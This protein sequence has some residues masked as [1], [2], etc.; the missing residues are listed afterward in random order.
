MNVIS[1]DLGGTKLTSAIIDHEGTV[2]TKLTGSVPGRGGDATGD[3]ICRTTEDLL[4]HA[5]REKMPVSAIGVAVP[6]IYRPDSG[7]VWA[8]NIPGWKDYPLRSRIQSAIN[9][10]E[11]TIQVDSDRACY[12]LGETWKGIAQ[13]YD[14]AIFIAV[15]TGIGA[16]IL[17]DNRILQGAQGIAGAT[18][19]MALDRP[20]KSEYTLCGYF[21]Y[22]ASGT[23]IVTAARGYLKD[24]PQYDGEL[25]KIPSKDLTAREVF[26]SH[27]R[28][29]PIA[30]RVLSECVQLWGMAVANFVSLFNPEIIVF[31]GGIFG[32][33]A[34]FL[35]QIRS[36]AERWAQPISIHQVQ[37]VQ[38]ALGGDAGLMGAGRLAFLSTD[39]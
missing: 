14:H 28:D 4:D 12:I 3:L 2:H 20:F 35:D 27:D 25:R 1:H 31:G 16:G 24:W 21:E 29:D 17:I 10:R 22:H 33:G 6:G 26:E 9:R 36:E 34:R 37:I 13:G 15:G 23:G 19:W 5:Q 11:V 18:G 30:I 7:T 8:P 32:P 39:R 38:S